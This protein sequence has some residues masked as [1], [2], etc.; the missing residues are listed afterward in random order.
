MDR[1]TNQ[2]RS[3]RKRKKSQHK[4]DSFVNE[5]YKTIITQRSSENDYPG[6]ETKIRGYQVA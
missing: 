1:E 4:A 3:E 5:N 6:T 2:E